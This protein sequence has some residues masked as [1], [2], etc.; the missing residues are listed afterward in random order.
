MTGRKEQEQEPGRKTAVFSKSNA[1]TVVQ[2]INNKLKENPLTTMLNGYRKRRGTKSSS[3]SVIA[4]TEEQDSKADDDF[5]N[6]NDKNAETEQEDAADD[7]DN[8]SDKNAETEAAQDVE[9]D[10]NALTE[11][12]Q[13]V[14]KNAQTVINKNA[15]TQ[16]KD[17]L[18]NQNDKNARTQD[19]EVFDNQ[20]DNI[21]Q[22]KEEE[23]T[24]VDVDDRLDNVYDSKFAA[25]NVG[26]NTVLFFGCKVNFLNL[27][28]ISHFDYQNILTLFLF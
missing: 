7:F 22:T 27:L 9:V 24:V 8:Q 17:H 18:D 4:Q 14:D 10:K 1:K 3:S 11:E 15:Q 6:Q 21:A 19:K 16:G 28:L 25:I 2:V 12:G 26:D 23:D 20:N 5:D 13:D